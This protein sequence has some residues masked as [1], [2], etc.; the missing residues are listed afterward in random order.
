MKTLRRF[1]SHTNYQKCR[2]HPIRPITQNGPIFTVAGV[3][4]TTHTHVCGAEMTEPLKLCKDCKWVKKPGFFDDAAFQCLNP[5]VL[6]ANGY[7]LVDGEKGPICSRVR[8]AEPE[9]C[10]TEGKFWEPREKNGIKLKLCKDCKW[11]VKTL[12]LALCTHKQAEITH[13]DLV[14]GNRSYPSACERFRNLDCGREGKFW[15]AK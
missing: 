8:N 7:Y 1:F 12:N 4:E 2:H 9:I 10:G 15:E 6:S 11:F 13:A 3:G 14:W 5:N